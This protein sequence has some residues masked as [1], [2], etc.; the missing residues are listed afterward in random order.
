MKLQ[1][2]LFIFFI[3][4]S[5]VQNAE[6]TTTKEVFY[7]YPNKYFIESGTY[8]GNGVLMALQ[9]P[10][11][12]VYS[13][14]LAQHHYIECYNKFA[15]YPNVHLFLGDSTNIMP[16]ILQQIKAPATFWLDGHYSWD[17]TARG[18]TN[19]P[20]LEELE[21]IKQHHI[22]NHTILI[23]DI[24]QCGTIHFDFIELDEIIKKILEINHN[25]IITF[26]D[27]HVSN[28]ILVAKIYDK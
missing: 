14:E 4:P 26:E 12:Q 13:I 11:E 7:K 9:G 24:R 25:Y 22:K 27:G 19:T 17:T 18:N 23:D 10:F 1:R 15:H 20:I 8:L 16:Q 5:L 28:D 2:F 3:L 21:A 6:A